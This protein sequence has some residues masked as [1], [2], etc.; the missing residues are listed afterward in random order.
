QIQGGQAFTA[1]RLMRIGGNH[2]TINYGGVSPSVL[3]DAR[4]VQNQIAGG[5][6]VETRLI[7]VTSVPEGYYGPTHVKMAPWL[8]GDSL[9]IQS[10]SILDLDASNLNG[11]LNS[12]FLSEH[13]GDIENFE[14]R[15]DSDEL[16][17][18]QLAEGRV[19]AV[20]PDG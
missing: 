17:G 14:L 6:Q 16:P 15:L 4:S 1:D 9:V 3:A 5:R 11:L 12:L 10:G 7:T 20:G 13:F 18:P 2:P 19:D 8:T